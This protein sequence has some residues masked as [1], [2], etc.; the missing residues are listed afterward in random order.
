MNRFQKFE[1]VEGKRFSVFGDRAFAGYFIFRKKLHIYGQLIK[2][3]LL[4]FLHVLYYYFQRQYAVLRGQ[5]QQTV[6]FVFLRFV[7]GITVLMLVY[8]I[9][10]K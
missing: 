5:V 4:L 9:H 6:V 3:Y 2:I 8:Q 10:C 1:E 7:F